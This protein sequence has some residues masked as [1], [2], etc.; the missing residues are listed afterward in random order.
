MHKIIEY[1]KLIIDFIRLSR[2]YYLYFNNSNI[3]SKLFYGKIQMYTSYINIQPYTS[4]CIKKKNQYKEVRIR[5]KY[6]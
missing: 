5:F 4:I 3:K 1:I 2:K 6:F